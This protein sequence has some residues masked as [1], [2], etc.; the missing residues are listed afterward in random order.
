M[1]YDPSHR[2]PPRQ[3]RWPNATPQEG[4]PAYL[5][6]DGHRDDQAWAD[7]GAYAGVRSGRAAAN[8]HG[9]ADGRGAA[10]YYGDTGYGDTGYGDTWDGH[11]GATGPYPGC[12]G[13][14]ETY[15]GTADSFDRGYGWEGGQGGDYLYRDEY[16][17]ADPATRSDPLLIAPDTIAERGWLPDR[18]GSAGRDRDRSGPAIGAVMGFLAAAVA[19]GVSTFAAAFVRPQASPIIAVGGAFIDRTPSALKNFA[20]QHFGENDKTVLLAGMYVTI[21]LIAMAIGCLALRNVTIGVAGLAVFG[22]FGAFVAITRPEARVT[23][24]VPSVIG[25]IAGVAALL[26]LARAAAPI[27]PARAG[28]ARA[29]SFRHAYSSGHSHRRAR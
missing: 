22:L 4:W 8:G 16:A 28:P 13:A 7:A 9:A 20:V 1:S 27:T 19:I 26:W 3:E 5:G 25:G 18:D 29:S 24:V 12:A 23:D 15:P 6:G 17:E 14:T 10:T 11:A 2:R 21:A